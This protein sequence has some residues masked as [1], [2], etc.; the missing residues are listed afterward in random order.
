VALLLSL[1]AGIGI[2]I[3][4][5]PVT[6][7]ATRIF[8]RIDAAL[9]IADEG[10]DHVKTSLTRASER[11]DRAREEQR[12]LSQGPRRNNMTQ[13]L[14]ARTVLPRIAPDFGD[15]HE[16]L[17]K[18]AE[19]AVVV[20]SVLEDVGNFPFLSVAGLDVGDLTQVNSLLSQV[21]SRAWDL[22]RLLGEPPSDPDSDAVGPQLSRIEQA[23]K[24][25]QRLLAEYEPHLT[26]VRQRTEQL[27]SS[28]FSWITPAAILV[29]FVCFWIALSQV[30]LLAHAWAWWRQS[31]RNQL[32]SFS[33]NAAEGLGER[34]EPR[35]K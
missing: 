9:D 6:T 35:S 4:K 21:E 34:L 29:S 13:R 7:K 31:G 32:K 33:S 23:L 16:T 15:A 17:H 10:L 27:K 5:E 2:W 20:N 30:S 8:E 22:S 25:M 11:L 28:I 12:Q 24:T 26:Q 18:V 19:A 14:L 1:A 3:V